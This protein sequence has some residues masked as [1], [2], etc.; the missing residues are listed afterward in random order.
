LCDCADEALHTVN[1]I[2]ARSRHHRASCRQHAALLAQNVGWSALP[3]LPAFLPR[4]RDGIH[5]K[6]TVAR[7][8]CL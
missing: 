5:S 4:L 6:D 7:H 1:A 3:A 8:A 2:I